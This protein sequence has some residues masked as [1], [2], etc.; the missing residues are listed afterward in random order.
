V[1]PWR[2]TT[3]KG[4]FLPLFNIYI[5]VYICIYVYY[6]GNLV[7]RGSQ[8]PK[9]ASIHFWSSLVYIYVAVYTGAP[10]YKLCAPE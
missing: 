10:V 2:T 8:G 4:D 6:R 5:Y 3:L 1:L 7:I 9:F